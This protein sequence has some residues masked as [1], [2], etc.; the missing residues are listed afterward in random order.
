MLSEYKIKFK[1]ARIL[2]EIRSWFCQKFNNSIYAVLV[3]LKT[4]DHSI[5]S[6]WFFSKNLRRCN[7]CRVDFAKNLRQSNLNMFLCPN[8]SWYWFAR[9]I[10]VIFSLNHIYQNVFMYALLYSSILPRS[11]MAIIYS[12]LLL[13]FL[14]FCS[15][16]LE[17]ISVARSQCRWSAE[18]ETCSDNRLPCSLIKCTSFSIVFN[19]N[20]IIIILF[21]HKKSIEMFGTQTISRSNRISLPN[22]IQYNDKFKPYHQR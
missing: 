10:T 8:V 1:C 9:S 14:A 18:K 20:V 2:S 5:L 3:L 13:P 4:S 12:M 19:P 17:F 22:E 6:C 15:N 7:L 11:R 16:L 21:L